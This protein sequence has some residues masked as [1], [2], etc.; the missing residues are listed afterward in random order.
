[1]KRIFYYILLKIYGI[2]KTLNII[3]KG[4]ILM[5]K[6]RLVATSKA[7]LREFRR[8]WRINILGRKPMGRPRKRVSK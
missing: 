2:S 7:I 8:S 3:Q 4:G 1:M 5:K 6:I